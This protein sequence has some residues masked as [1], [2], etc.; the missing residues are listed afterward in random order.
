MSRFFVGCLLTVLI[1]PGAIPAQE[2][3]PKPLTPEERAR[4]EM[5]AFQLNQ[6]GSDLYR[7]GRFAEAVKRMEAALAARKRLYP[8]GEFPDGHPELAMSLNNLGSVL[9]SLGRAAQALP[10]YEEALA[11]NRRLFP[12]SKYPIGHSD[13]AH[14]LNNLG[15]VL[16][17]LGRADQ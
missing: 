2:D 1:G 7:A 4:L 13:L 14:S 6:E 5:E 10:R 9:Q 12:E 17:S 15:S 16:E 8:H 3:K 11:M